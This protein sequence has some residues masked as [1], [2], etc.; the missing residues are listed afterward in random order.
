MPSDAKK[1]RDAAKKNATKS[2]GKA[3]DTK[4]KVDEEDGVGTPVNELENGVE[5]VASE[6]GMFSL[7]SVSDR[8]IFLVLP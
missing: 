1:A 8:S 5:S 3:R 4:A 6:N 7:R 2:R